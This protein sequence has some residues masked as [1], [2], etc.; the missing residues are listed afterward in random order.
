MSL[1][2]KNSFGADRQVSDEQLAREKA[3]SRK[4]HLLNRLFFVLLLGLVPG[5]LVISYLS[6]RLIGSNVL[7]LIFVS[8]LVLAWVVVIIA[9]CCLVCPQCGKAFFQK[10][11]YGNTFARRCLHCNFEPW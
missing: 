11:G 8:L 4:Y 10:T 7:N 6:Q 9:Q 3:W 5:T 1:N 2:W